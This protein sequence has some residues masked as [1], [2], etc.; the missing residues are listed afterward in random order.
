MP[1]WLSNAVLVICSCRFLK[2]SQAILRTTFFY[3]H[4]AARHSHIYLISPFQ[5][6]AR[7]LRGEK[8]VMCEKKIAQGTKGMC[9]HNLSDVICGRGREKKKMIHMYNLV[10]CFPFISLK[11]F[12]VCV[13]QWH[14][15]LSHLS[16]S[17]SPKRVIYLAI[18]THDPHR[19]CGFICESSH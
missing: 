15:S 1:T 3:L 16:H 9:K 7:G 13:I 10:Y 4:F 18:K 17:M 11:C 5:K 19:C 6:E 12:Y 14:T 8:T 2:N